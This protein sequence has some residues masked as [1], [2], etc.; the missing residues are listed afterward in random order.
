MLSIT[1]SSSRVFSTASSI[2]KLSLSFVI[3][4]TLRVLSLAN[5]PAGAVTVISTS[6]SD[7]VAENSLAASSITSTLIVGSDESKRAYFSSFLT[8]E[9]NLYMPG[10]FG[11]YS[12]PKLASFSHESGSFITEYPSS[13][14]P[15]FSLI[16]LIDGFSSPDRSLLTSSRCSSVIKSMFLL[17]TDFVATSRSETDSSISLKDASTITETASSS[18][19]LMV[20]F[21]MLMP[22]SSSSSSSISASASQT[23]AYIVFGRL[24]FDSGVPNSTDWYDTSSGRSA[25]TFTAYSDMACSTGFSIA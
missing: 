23:N 24:S 22:A 2:F 20:A 15:V 14:S 12:P 13:S 4:S 7:H 11:S 17:I 1:L 10:T 6:S 9:V 5:T 25:N 3:F 21:S 18:I 8:S 16:S 19:S